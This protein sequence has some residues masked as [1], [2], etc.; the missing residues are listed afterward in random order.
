MLHK[1]L[2]YYFRYLNHDVP[3]GVVVFLVALPLCLGIA[4]ASGAPPF[5]GVVAGIVGGLIVSVFSGSQLSVSGPAAGLTVI[6]ALAA[7]KYGFRGMLA[8]TM[9]AG[10]M[11][12]AMAVL[13]AGVIGAYFPSA[14]IKGMLA[15]IGVILIMKQLPHALGYDADAESDLSFVEDDSN[16]TFSFVWEA[17]GSLSLGA[18]VVSVVSLA[19]LLLWETP[20]I[21]KNRFLSLAPAPLIAVLFGVAYN[22]LTTS[23][24]PAFAI[25]AQH[26][27]A[28]PPI[29]GPADFIGHLQLPDFSRL[30]D[31]EIF[32]TA[33][34][35]ALVGSLET[36]LSLEAADK[37]DP[38]KR[39]APTNQEL[40]AQGVGNFVSGMLGGLPIT[41]VIVRSSANINAGA[42]T[43]IASIVH[44]ALLLL[45]VMFLA[46]FLNM[47]PLACLAAVLLLTGYKLAKP[48]LLME[49]YAKGFNQFAP[50]A[51]TIAAIL[52]TDLLKGIAIGMAVGLFFVLRANYFSAFTLTKDGRNYLLR[53]QKDLSFLHKAPLRATLESIDEGS[54]V[55]IDGARAS[56]IDHD[57]L[58]ALQDFIL[59]AGDD[60]ISVEL[61]NVRGLSG[62]NGSV[63]REGIESVVS[64]P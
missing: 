51:I 20:L 7:E 33:A 11:Q 56:F 29:S 42:H 25:Q 21:K 37:L 62:Q 19:I 2:N 8:A 18:I 58:E 31:P 47:I 41:A 50:F 53:L 59:A 49:Q 63:R 28:L 52:L 23:A 24:F 4:V 40:T 39:T 43:K 14:V 3:A 10:L 35:L 61:K 60:N 46:H 26:L 57:I 5:S 27:V 32:V 15:A 55:V 64:C 9:L 17:L 38:L 16:A 44:G 22:L 1:H 45:S 54:Y 34:T 6:V 36:L 12:L 30:K 13:R 48:Q